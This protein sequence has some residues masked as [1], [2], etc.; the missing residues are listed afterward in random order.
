MSQPSSLK[1]MCFLYNLT[2][3]SKV[4]RNQLLCVMPNQIHLLIS[5]LGKERK[6][7]SSLIFA[8]L[9]SEQ[10]VKELDFFSF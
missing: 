4:T 10:W 7:F 2:W 8:S 1:H 3:S 6:D 5:V 9:A